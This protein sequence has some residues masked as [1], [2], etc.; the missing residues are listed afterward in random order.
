MECQHCAAHAHTVL[1]EVSVRGIV[2]V[3]C[4]RWR[5]CL[6]FE[7]LMSS[8]AAE[9]QVEVWPGVTVNQ[10]V[11]CVDDSHDTLAWMVTETFLFNQ[12]SLKLSDVGCSYCN[13][14]VAWV[15]VCRSLFHHIG[16]PTLLK[17]YW[18]S[19]LVFNYKTIEDARTLNQTSVKP[20]TSLRFEQP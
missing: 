6:S 20:G 4:F 12:L 14:P 7:C 17:Y 19:I 15:Q 3:W 16:K 9:S 5:V 11:K 13:T 2:V 8:A 18:P 10:T 1:S